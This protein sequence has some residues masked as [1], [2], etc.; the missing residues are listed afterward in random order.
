MRQRGI[1]DHKVLFAIGNAAVILTP[2][3]FGG[4]A[5][6]IRA[7]DAMVNA[8]LGATDAREE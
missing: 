4:V 2:S 5:A 1:D 8:S 3:H 7:G 6:E